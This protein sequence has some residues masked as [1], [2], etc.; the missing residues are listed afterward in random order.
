MGGL[1]VATLAVRPTEVDNSGMNDPEPDASDAA[2]GSAEASPASAHGLSDAALGRRLQILS[3]E[4]WGLLAARTTAQ[5]EVLTRISL[6]LAV[7]SAGLL[8]IGLLGQATAFSAWFAPAALSLLGFLLVV[9]VLTQI[10]VFNVAEE[11]LMY[12]VG[13][14]RLRSAYVDID[15]ETEDLF[16]AASADDLKG[17]E[18]TYSFISRRSSASVML[19]SSAFL[20]VLVNAC[21]MGL[22]V[23]GALL[24]MG[25]EMAWSVVAGCLAGLLL[26]AGSAVLVLRSYRATWTDYVPRRRTERPPA[27]LTRVGSRARRRE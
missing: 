19:G 17:M 25:A 13:M 5:N 23:A 12:V 22:L 4:H 20:I 7:F 1:S 8:T 10:R 18:R 24:T 9:G 15:P 26:I 27:H 2:R 21:L 6:F 3:T 14:N 16:L 11:D